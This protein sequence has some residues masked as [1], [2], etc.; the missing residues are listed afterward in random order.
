MDRRL[1]AILAADVVGYSR[2]MGQDEA[3]TLKALK[4]LRRE[5]VEPKIAGHKGRIFK[6]TGDGMLVE[7]PSVVNAVACAVDIQHGMQ[8]RNADVPEARA[9]RLR[10]GVNI[11]DVIVE[12]DDIFGDGVN[13]A[14][15]LEA[16]APP[17]GVAVS[18]VVRDQIGNR[19]E[20]VFEDFGEQ[21][22]KNIDRPVKVYHVAIRKGTSAAAGPVAEATPMR[23]SIAVL[24]FANMSGDPEQRYFSDGITEDIITELSRFRAWFVIARNSSFQ[25][26][27]RSVDIRRVAQE[28]GVQYVVEGSVRKMGDRVRITAQLIDATT[29]NHLWSERYDRNID[30]LFELQD[31]VTSTIVAT[32]TGRVENAEIAGSVRKRTDNLAAYDRLLRGI[33]HV[34]GYGDDENRLA[35]ELFQEAIA[36][37]PRFALA[38]AYLSV[39]LLL[40]HGYEN[41]PP[42]IKDRA[43]DAA[44]ISVRLDPGESRCHAFLAV[45]YLERGEFDMALSHFERMAALNPSD[46]N[47]ISNMGYALAAVGRAEEGA[48]MIRQAMRLNPF[49][50]DW[51][52]ADLASVLYDAR[53]YEEAL[54][55]HKHLAGRKKYWLHAR[56]AACYGQLR[57]LDE[58]HE[59]VR[60][61]LRL[62]PDFRISRERLSYKIRSTPNMCSRACARQGSRTNRPSFHKGGRMIRSAAH[63]PRGST[64]SSRVSTTAL[65]VLSKKPSSPRSR[66]V[67]ALICA[68][69]SA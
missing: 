45:A 65:R 63:G 44:L 67:R 5:L 26:R 22:L 66:P 2:L 60:E 46:A 54:D 11:G 41:A 6:A 51:Y 28:L 39:A 62:K 69:K 43:V 61:V 12:G 3:G 29:N 48:E 13:V 59:Q 58:A 56:R 52:W 68:A 20:V 42:D 50:P 53:R 36:L 32:L 30:A 40:E 47:G 19:L 14:A 18:G 57:R 49:H 38:H 33:D 35:R 31:E 17:G 34:R 1:A 55:A 15:R 64:P 23:P 8:A 4:V 25:Y 24:P 27:D 10:I 37:D 16:M 7:F 9:V 21:E